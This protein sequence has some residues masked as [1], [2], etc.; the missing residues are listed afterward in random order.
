LSIGALKTQLKSPQL[1]WLSHCALFLWKR[2]AAFDAFVQRFKG[3]ELLC[4]LKAG[5]AFIVANAAV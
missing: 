3:G 5:A 4:F 2:A 1:Q